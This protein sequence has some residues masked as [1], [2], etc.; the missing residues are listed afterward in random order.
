MGFIPGWAIGVTVIV[1]ASALAKILLAKVRASVPPLPSSGGE[2]SELRE[3]ID[4][5]QNRLGEL[6]ER[7]DFTE[8]LLAKHR[9]ADRLAPPSTFGHP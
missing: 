9:E 4:A 7:V 8:R 2:T 1:F 6:E 5:M 3:A